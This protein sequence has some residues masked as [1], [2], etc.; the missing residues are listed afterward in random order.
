MRAIKAP[1]RPIWIFVYSSRARS[2]SAAIEFMCHRFS[3][4]LLPYLLMRKRQRTFSKR[5]SRL[6]ELMT[7][8]QLSQRLPTSL[9]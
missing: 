4:T 3:T 1:H 7:S 6:A 9:H 2:R 5:E 8:A